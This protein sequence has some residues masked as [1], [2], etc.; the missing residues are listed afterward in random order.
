MNVE[1]SS[2]N[3]TRTRHGNARSTHD[4]VH[5]DSG[6]AQILRLDV[7]DRSPLPDVSAPTA[8]AA[9]RAVGKTRRVELSA[10]LKSRRARI[11]PEDVGLVP[12]ARRRTPGLRREEVAQLAG[13]GVTWY[14]WLEQGRDIN[15][16]VQVLDA[17]SRTLCLDSAERGHLYRLADVPTIPTPQVEEAVPVELQGILDQLDPLPAVLLSARYDVL[18]H[19]SAYAA[20]CPTF[21]RGDKNLIRTVFCTP[22]CCNPNAGDVEQLARMVG[23]LR[24]A[25]GRNLHDPLWTEFIDDV[26][27][28]SPVFAEMWARNDVA[29]PLTRTKMIRNLAAGE[30][31]MVVTSMSLP[32]IAGSWVQIKTPAN[33][34][35]W[36][37]LRELLAMSEQERRQPWLDHYARDHASCL[38][39]RLAPA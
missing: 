38:P 11:R 20:L 22:D 12:G 23:F 7:A 27:A 18:A 14:T 34:G 29:H 26:A 1:P 35:S 32:T 24:I 30:L 36:A 6:G 19:N 25:Y 31:E 10:F 3:G 17:I 28:R 13:V 8:G 9:A 2:E 15:A 37:M 16:S 33:A 39:E 5:A 4:A 21:V